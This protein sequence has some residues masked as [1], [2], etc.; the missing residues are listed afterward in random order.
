MQKLVYKLFIRRAIVLC[1][2]CI[3]IDS[4][5]ESHSLYRDSTGQNCTGF[6]N[7]W[8]HDILSFFLALHGPCFNGARLSGHLPTRW[9]ERSTHSAI[10]R[11]TAVFR[12]Q[13]QWIGVGSRFAGGAGQNQ[14]R[15]LFTVGVQ[16]ALHTHRF[17]GI[18]Q[19]GG[20][21]CMHTKI[22]FRSLYKKRP[23]IW[24]VLVLYIVLV[25]W[26]LRHQPLFFRTPF[27]SLGEL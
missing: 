19:R 25:E 12:G 15:T 6:Q 16:F 21:I 13:L 23:A 26:V 4:M 27:V 14:Q 1:E 9:W 18:G 17:T 5:V 8:R 7:Q 22:V 20:R 24:L 3:I 11:S 10:F 2:V